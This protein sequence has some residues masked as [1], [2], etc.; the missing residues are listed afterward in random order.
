MHYYHLNKNSK[1]WVYYALKIMH[2]HYLIYMGRKKNMCM[3]CICM[4]VYKQF[5]RID[6]IMAANTQTHKPFVFCPNN[7]ILTYRKSSFILRRLYLT[8]EVK[9][10]IYL[11]S[12]P[13][14]IFS[15][16]SIIYLKCLPKIHKQDLEF[17]KQAYSF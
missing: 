16:W 14:I 17:Y 3:W 2:L 6:G 13:Q 11:W 9:Q 4:M 15:W 10:D 12:I 5:N 8:N 1:L 7:F